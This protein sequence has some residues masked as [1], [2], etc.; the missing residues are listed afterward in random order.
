MMTDLRTHQ[1]RSPATT[2]CNIAAM[3][4]DSVP[5]DGK[6]QHCGCS[7]T[8]TVRA[9]GMRTQWKEFIRKYQ[10]K[11]ESSCVPQAVHH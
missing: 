11:R 5:R 1:A 3:K 6:T 10:G 8:G 2:H 9:V 7:R 4:R